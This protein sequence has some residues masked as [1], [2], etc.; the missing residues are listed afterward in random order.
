MKIP[1]I[2]R[3]AETFDID[4]PESKQEY[5]KIISNPLT[6]VLSRSEIKKTDESWEGE[7]GGKEDSITI[8]LEWEEKTL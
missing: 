5:D 1:N 2:K 6:T 8:L 4:D 3:F 7:S